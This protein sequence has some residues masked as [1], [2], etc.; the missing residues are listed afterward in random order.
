MSALGFTIVRDTREKKPY[1]FRRTDCTDEA[2]TTGD[3]TV[4]GFEDTFAI[5][6]KSLP[7]FLKSITWE[8]DRFKREIKRGDELLAFTVVIEAPLSDITNWNYDREVHPN[9]VL[10][11]VENWSAYHN[12]EFH[13]GG[14]RQG[15]KD[16][17]FD[18]LESWYNAH[19][20]MLES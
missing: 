18:T 9:S 1:N 10:G 4:E 11:T 2:L 17:T 8:R 3:Y 16:F 6:R 15:A 19:Q 14:D 13:W 12:V 5:E 7:D 20:S